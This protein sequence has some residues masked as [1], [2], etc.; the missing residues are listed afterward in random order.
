VATPDPFRGQ[1]KICVVRETL[2]IS[3]AIIGCTVADYAHL[4]GARLSLSLTRAC[5][6]LVTR[7]SD[8]ILRCIFARSTICFMFEHTKNY[9]YNYNLT[10][11]D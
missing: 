1:A 3:R 10:I 8:M 6:P 5:F 11:R 2:A 4:D 7:I 9:N